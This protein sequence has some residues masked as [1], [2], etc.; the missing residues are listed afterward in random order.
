MAAYPKFK[1]PK[2]FNVINWAGMGYESTKSWSELFE[3]DTGVKVHV[4]PE[5]DT[6]N[7]FRWLGMGMFQLTG[8]NHSET[9]QMLM[10]DRKYATRDGGPI[11]VRSVWVHSKNNSG[12]FMRGDC[13]MKT[14][15]DIK[16]GTKMVHMTY[17]ANTRVVEGL[18]AWAKV[19]REEID[20]IPA[21]NSVEN[22]KLVLEG[23]AE[24][25]FSFPNSPTMREAEKHPKGIKWMVLDAAMDPDGA[26]RFQTIDPLIRFGIIPEG[27]VK[28]AAGVPSTEG[29]VYEVTL[30]TTDPA[31]V[32]NLAK[33]FDLNFK[34]I[35]K[36]HPDNTF[37]NRETLARGLRYTYI[38]CHEG[39]IEYLKELKI[40]TKA[41][42]IR[43]KENTAL[44]DR[45]RESYPKAIEQADDKQ[46]VVDPKNPDWQKF[47]AEY[48]KKLK[49]PDFKLF[50]DLPAAKR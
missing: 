5:F 34:R 38:P 12:F 23:K 32:Y 7:R 17:V 48:K 15:Y 31:F 41:H 46:I 10:A 4:A 11:P 2:R 21:N 44:I 6:V 33:W 27:G 39:L 50:D 13:K 22:Y 8:G 3:K 26:R 42:D 40:W 16:P 43:Q 25:G 28:S 36:R 35:Q 9:S 30:A 14:P 18:L 20:W 1:W 45:Y 37:K 24:L 47:W 49:I 29:I 19:K